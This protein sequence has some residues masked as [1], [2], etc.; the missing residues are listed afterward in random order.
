[1]AFI[2]L[3]YF[4]STN[5]LLITFNIKNKI[6]LILN[7]YKKNFKIFSDS[8][9]LIFHELLDIWIININIIIIILIALL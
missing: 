1:M 8:L 4:I 9:K 2:K 7:F 5:F 6:Y 3:Y